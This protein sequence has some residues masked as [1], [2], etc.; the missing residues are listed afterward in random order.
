MIKV[1][2]LVKYNVLPS[3][4]IAVEDSLYCVLISPSNLVTVRKI[5][6]F[7]EKRFEV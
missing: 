5:S 7:S 3:F 1:L 2:F 4:V 6:F